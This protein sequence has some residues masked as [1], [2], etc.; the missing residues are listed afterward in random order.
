MPLDTL[1]HYCARVSHSNK[2]LPL[3]LSLMLLDIDNNGD[4]D[5]LFVSFTRDEPLFLVNFNF[6]FLLSFKLLLMLLLLSL[7]L[8]LQYLFTPHSIKPVDVLQTSR[9]Q[10]IAH[11]L[12]LLRRSTV[13][14]LE[15]SNTFNFMFDAVFPSSITISCKIKQS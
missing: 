9:D 13:S 7:L 6:F 10:Y 14:T 11:A 4:H 5:N 8:E 1:G 3:A 2:E 12:L 15:S